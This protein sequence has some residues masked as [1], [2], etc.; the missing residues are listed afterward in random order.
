MCRSGMRWSQRYILPSAAMGRLKET[1]SPRE[2]GSS[3]PSAAPEQQALKATGPC[4]A[5]SQRPNY[6]PPQRLPERDA[7]GMRR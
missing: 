5:L 6:P 7:L 4:S 1:L 3:A 2:L